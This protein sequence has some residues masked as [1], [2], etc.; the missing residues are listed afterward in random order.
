MFK[1]FQWT[2]S[3]YFLICFLGRYKAPEVLTV[4]IES[5][6][7]PWF[8]GTQ[9]LTSIAGQWRYTD[10]S[11][12]C[13]NFTRTCFSLTETSSLIPSYH[14][15]WYRQL[16][17]LPIWISSMESSF[18]FFERK[19]GVNLVR[20]ISLKITS[21]IIMQSHNKMRKSLVLFCIQ[22]GTWW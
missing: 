17:K 4:G 10:W 8:T 18:P 15:V 7:N 12:G 14:S 2:F 21:Y 11:V 3:V 6:C 13:K 20:R 5:N 9:D 22:E 16:K 19:L 1:D